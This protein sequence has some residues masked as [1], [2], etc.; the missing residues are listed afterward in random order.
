MAGPA[1]GATEM[2]EGCCVKHQWA[3]THLFVSS[4]G[5]LH[6]TRDADWSAKPLRPGFMGHRQKIKSIADFKASVR[7]GGFAWPGGYPVVF[8]CDDGSVLCHSCIKRNARSVMDSL[9][10]KIRDGWRVMGCQIVEG[11]EEEIC[12]HCSTEIGG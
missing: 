11:D 7:A 12:D 6:D 4:C 8:V 3:P 10:H 2:K 1:K 9:T 5:D